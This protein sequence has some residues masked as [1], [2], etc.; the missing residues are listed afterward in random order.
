MRTPSFA[1]ERTIVAF[2]LSISWK[3]RFSLFPY[4][5]RRIFSAMVDLLVV[6]V[7]ELGDVPG[8]KKVRN[9]TDVESAVIHSA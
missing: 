4:Q 6:E 2:P 9:S 7:A 8:R 1:H 5:G 3:Q